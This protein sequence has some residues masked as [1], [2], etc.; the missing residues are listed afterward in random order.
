MEGRT[1]NITK[2]GSSM[3]KTCLNAERLKEGCIVHIA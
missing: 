3:F 1:Q 2:N